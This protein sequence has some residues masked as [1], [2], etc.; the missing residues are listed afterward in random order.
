MFAVYAAR[1]NPE[2]RPASLVDG[3]R[4]EPEVPDGWVKVKISYASLN[5]HDLFTLR[6]ITAHPDPIPFQ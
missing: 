3:E 5:R 1:S 2:N 4:P 6:G